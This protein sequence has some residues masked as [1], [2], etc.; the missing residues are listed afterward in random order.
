MQANRRWRSPAERLN[1]HR[2]HDY[3]LQNLLIGVSLA[4]SR[5][6]MPKKTC[7]RGTLLL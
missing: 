7:R 1:P 2:Y 3:W 5:M 4:E 6:S